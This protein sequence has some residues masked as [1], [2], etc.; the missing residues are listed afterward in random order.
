MCGGRLPRR[1]RGAR[2]GG[3]LPAARRAA[4]ARGAARGARRTT[5][6]RGIVRRRR[7][8]PLAV[9]ASTP[10]STASPP[11]SDELRR[12]V[13]AGQ[14]DSASELAEGAALLGRAS[15]TVEE[16]LAATAGDRSELD[17]ARPPLEVDV[18]RERAR[19][20]AWYELF[21]RSW[22]GFAGVAQVLP[23]LAELGFDVVYL[24]P[25][26]PIGRDEPQGPQQRA[27]RRSPATPA[28]RGRS[29]RRRAATTALHPELGTMDDFDAPRRRA[30]ASSGIE[31][32]LD[33]AIQCSPDH[34]WL[35]RAP[36]VV[37]PP[38]RRHAQVRREPAQALPG[39]L[40]RQLR[41][42]R[43]GEGAVGRRCAT[44]SSLWVERGVRV[45][46][47]DNPHTKPLPFWE[48]LIARGAGARTRTSIFLAEAFTRPAMMATL[49]KAGFNQSYT[50]FTWKNTKAG[51][52][53]VHDAAGA[54]ELPE[55]YRPNFFANTPDILHEYLQ[56]GGRPAFEARLVLA[57]TLSPIVRDLLR[58]RALRER[59]A[60]GRA[61][62]STSTPR[63]TRSKKRRARR[64]A[65]AARRAAERGPARE[66]GAAAARQPRRSSR[67][68]TTHLIAYVKRSGGERRHR[69]ASTSTRA[70]SREGVVIVPGRR[71]ACRRRSP[72][73]TCSPASVLAG[74]S[75][76]TTCG[77]D[78]GRSAHVLP[79]VDARDAGMTPRAPAALVRARPAVV[80]AGGLLRDPHPR[81]LRRQRRRLRRLPRADREARLPRSGSASTASGCCR[82]TR[83]R[84]ATAATTSP[85]ST[86]S[87][88]D[89]GDGR[90]L[91]AVRRGGPPAR[92]PRDRRPRHEPHVVRPPVVPGVAVE[93]RRRR[94]ATGTS[95]R[96]PTTRYPEARIIFID[97][98]PS[99]WTWDPVAGQYYWHRFFSHQPDLNF[100]NPEV[101]EAM[102]DV[103][104]LL[105]RPRAST[106]SGSTP[107][108]TSS[109]ATARTARTC[110]RRT[111]T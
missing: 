41:H 29:A 75:A 42:A 70:R 65:A 31:I 111:R 48:W 2:R 56:R 24:P 7:A 108:R 27:R 85:T 47:V 89:Y 21:P 74:A 20:G 6:G 80:Q 35:T 54:L 9:R 36:G 63:S 64:A 51:A 33:F 39:H 59:A 76:A 99:N 5:A 68:R 84:C 37:P 101:Q 67:P 14:D 104:A 87:I 50:Y 73:P 11:G 45:F 8:R 44:S 78:P 86:R 52:G 60:C 34:P 106:A 109:S 66:P 18:D 38:P 110:P 77:L 81:L 3:A 19:F 57:A 88:R 105:A 10:G 32:A 61:A 46:R 58:L 16:A 25:V 43:T 93:P 71:S 72:S 23:E 107:C 13:E 28:A 90:G 83:R 98:E 96:T 26:H 1:P 102:L 95:G 53:R 97:T 103:A 4:L 22:G 82:C 91:P 100:D 12:K 94:S 17:V 55:F 15:L 30:R 79:E 62:R 49:A 40:Q 92:H 69:R